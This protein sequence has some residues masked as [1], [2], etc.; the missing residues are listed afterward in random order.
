MRLGAVAALKA[1]GQGRDI[2]VV[3][4]IDEML[5]PEAFLQFDPYHYE[6]MG[7]QMRHFHYHFNRLSVFDTP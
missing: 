1:M 5:S 2:I 3:G 6:W 4:D 7:T